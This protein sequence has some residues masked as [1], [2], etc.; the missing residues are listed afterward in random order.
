MKCDM[1]SRPQA[2][3]H[4]SLQLL[5]KV[6]R[7]QPAVKVKSGIMLGLGES[8]DEVRG[9]LADL[10]HVGCD[11]VTIG[12]YLQPSGEH[13]SVMRFWTPDEFSMF[14]EEALSMGFPWV[15]SGPLVRSSYRAEAPFVESVF[16]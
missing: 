5:A 14:K 1:V 15:E 4:R 13:F 16:N 6:K 8:M 12:Q 9:V 2:D 3:Y 7:D 10:K 11:I